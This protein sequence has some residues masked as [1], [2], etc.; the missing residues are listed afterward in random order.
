MPEVRLRCQH[1]VS[2]ASTNGPVDSTT[3]DWQNRGNLFLGGGG[4]SDPLG[5]FFKRIFAP[6]ENLAPTGKLAPTDKLAL[7]YS[8]RLRTSWHLRT[9]WRLRA[10]WRLRQF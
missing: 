2:Q 5:E 3:S 9:S 4:V 8:W 6:T 7:C 10:S 1:Q